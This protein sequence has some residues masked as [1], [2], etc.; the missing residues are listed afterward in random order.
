MIPQYQNT[1]SKKHNIK[2]IEVK[3]KKVVFQGL[4]NTGELV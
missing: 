2:K 4:E 3:N 1:V